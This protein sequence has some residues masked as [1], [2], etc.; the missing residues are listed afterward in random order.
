MS[1]GKKTTN[2]SRKPLCCCGVRTRCVHGAALCLSSPVLPE[3]PQAQP[4][5]GKS[6]KFL[7]QHHVVPP[8]DVPVAER[9]WPWFQ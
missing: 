3:L 8:L 1:V 9:C 7:G 5:E 4:L 6:R 2:Q